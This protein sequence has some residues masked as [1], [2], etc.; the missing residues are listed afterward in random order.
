MKTL[1]LVSLASVVCLVVGMVSLVQAQPAAE[2]VS[3]PAASP[4]P[5]ALQDYVARPDNSFAWKLTDKQEGAAGR[6]YDVALTSQTWQ[7]MPWKHDLVVFEPA[8]LKHPEHVLLFITGGSSQSTLRP[9]DRLLGT[10]L[11]TLCGM[12]VAL[13]PQI[14]NQ[15]LLGGR[16]EDDLISDTFLFY[17]ATNDARWPLLFP[18]VK[19]AVRS[20]VIRSHIW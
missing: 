1:S 4:V 15:P 13:L 19:S 16:T 17:L 2:A 6:A 18:M 11:A 10:S 8:Q 9:D 20:S 12:R 5:T 7:D 3:A 14:P